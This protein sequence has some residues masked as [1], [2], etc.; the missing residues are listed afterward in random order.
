MLEAGHSRNTV[1]NYLRDLRRLE[2]YAGMK[3]VTDP[4]RVTPKLLREFIFSLKDLGLSAATIRREISAIRTYYAFLVG[5]GG[6]KADPSER[7]ESPRRGRTSARCAHGE[8]DRRPAHGTRD[9]RA[10]GLARPGPARTRL[11]GG[12]AGLRDHAGWGWAT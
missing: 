12:D 7:L 3:G 9:G 5:E 10:A 2:A 4:G 6:L 11:R 8:G 1:E